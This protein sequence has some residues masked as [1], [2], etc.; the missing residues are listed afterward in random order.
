MKLRKAIIYVSGP[1]SGNTKGEITQNIKKAA[2]YALWVWKSGGIA[3][4]PHM[5]TA[6]FDNK[7]V[8]YA[9]FLHGDLVLLERCDAVFMIPGWELSNGAKVEKQHAEQLRIPI[10][11][12]KKDVSNFLEQCA[13]ANN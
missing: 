11:Y 6:H 4:C 3:L 10:L 5:N 13:L 1:Y 2:E 12:S 7:G 9:S 8:S